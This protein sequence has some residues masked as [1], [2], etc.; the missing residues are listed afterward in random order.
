[1]QGHKLMVV[2]DYDNYINPFSTDDIDIYSG[3]SYSVLLT[4]NQDPSQNYYIFVGVRGRKPNTTHALTMLNTAPASK[5]SSSPPP[6][7][8]RWDDFERS[9]NFSKK[10]FLAMGD[11]IAAEEIQKMF[12]SSQHSE[13]NRRTWQSTTSL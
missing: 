3:K 12:D 13:S 4:T 11:P 9:K 5:L 8:P 7:T 1:M 10:I 2:E 6:V